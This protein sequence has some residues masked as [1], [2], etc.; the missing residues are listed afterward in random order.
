[1]S[2]VR[3]ILAKNMK[4][5]RKRLGFSQIRLAEHAQLSVSFIGEIELGKKFPSAEK[6]ER[7]GKALGMR[8]YELIYD[9]EEGWEVHDNAKSTALTRELKERMNLLL[10]EIIYKHLKD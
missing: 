5:A 2:N 7:L 1:M 6:L 8:P 4:D 10:E 3:K 9:A